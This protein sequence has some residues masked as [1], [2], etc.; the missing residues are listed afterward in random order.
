[1]LAEVWTTSYGLLFV[2]KLPGAVFDPDDDPR[3]PSAPPTAVLSKRDRIRLARGQSK[4]A[5]GPGW[6]PIPITVERILLDGPV[7]APLWVKCA[8]HFAV[9]VDIVKLAKIYKLSQE[10]H[11]ER[12]TPE[13]MVI[14]LHDVVA[15]SS[16]R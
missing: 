9:E 14:Y 10:K 6:E 4:K 8:I 7:I 13:P 1:M 16:N 11:G 3:D 2:S 5:R 12:D 15:L